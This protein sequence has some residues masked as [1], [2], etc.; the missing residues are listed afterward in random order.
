MTCLP[1]SAPASPHRT[2]AGRIRPS[3]LREAGTQLESEDLAILGML[4]HGIPPSEIAATL[5]M[6]ERWLIARRWAMLEPLAGKPA[7]RPSAR[8]AIASAPRAA[9]A[10]ASRPS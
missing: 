9:P 3:A 4:A 5:T 7:R 8:S 10:G 1:P 6:D 2:T